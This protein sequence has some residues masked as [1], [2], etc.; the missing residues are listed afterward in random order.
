MKDKLVVVKIGGNI[1]ENESLMDKFLM[2]FV[3]IKDKKILIHGG[4]KTVT[5]FLVVVYL[6][7]N[8]FNFEYKNKFVNALKLTS[9]D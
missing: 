7:S 4:G 6:C 3:K 9:W 8:N 5:N 2:S 1:I